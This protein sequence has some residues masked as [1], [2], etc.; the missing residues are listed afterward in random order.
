[1]D[2]SICFFVGMLIPNHFTVHGADG[3]KGTATM[4]GPE[5]DLDL[6]MSKCSPC[7]SPCFLERWFDNKKLAKC[8][9]LKQGWE[10]R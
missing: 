10:N 3:L 8:S 5:L 1:M 6:R 2:T 7:F 4:L 9:L